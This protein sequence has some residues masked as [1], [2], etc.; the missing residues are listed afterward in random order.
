MVCMENTISVKELR[1]KLPTI[2]RQVNAG[3]RFIIIYHSQPVGDLVP[4]CGLHALSKD[5]LRPWQKPN[6]KFLF[7]NSVSAVNMIRDLRK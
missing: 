1:L 6:K 4:H 2:L 5:A 7:R 3:E